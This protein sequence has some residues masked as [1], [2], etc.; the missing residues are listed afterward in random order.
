MYHL[1]HHKLFSFSPPLTHTLGWVLLY[2]Q[3][4]WDHDKQGREGEE[5]RRE[6]R[7]G[8]E[9]EREEEREGGRKN[10]PQ[11][12]VSFRYYYVLTDAIVGRGLLLE[13]PFYL[14]HELGRRKR[15]WGEGRRKEE[16]EEEEKEEG[17]IDT[18]THVR[19]LADNIN[20]DRQRLFE[21]ESGHLPLK[22]LEVVPRGVPCAPC[23]N[24]QVVMETF[25]PTCRSSWRPSCQ[26]AGRHGDLR[27]NLQVAMKTFV[28]TCRS[29]W[30]P[31]CQPAGRHGDLRANLQVAMETFV[32]T[33]RSPWRPS[34]Q[35][36]GCHGD[37]RAN[38]Q[39]VMEIFRYFIIPTGHGSCPLFGGG[40]SDDLSWANLHTT[41]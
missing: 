39:V 41:L 31:S 18:R 5:R 28:P 36:A 22:L 6:E 8:R 20:N 25:V 35:P 19:Y 7:R 33:C 21:W 4:T 12:P 14:G 29:P 16:E 2:I 23:A 13:I 26:P 34:C 30:R 27:A 11:T 17:R 9:E 38:L 40:V 32:P 3:P 10:S 37:L 15:K 1:I 24:L